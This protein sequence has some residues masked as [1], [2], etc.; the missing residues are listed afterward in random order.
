MTKKEAT[1][2]VK[3]CTARILESEL[4]NGSE[5]LEGL[6]GEFTVSEQKKVVAAVQALIKKLC[7]ENNGPIPPEVS[8]TLYPGERD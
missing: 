8:E 5:W 4:D 7:P 6:D 1:E 3:R 2:Y